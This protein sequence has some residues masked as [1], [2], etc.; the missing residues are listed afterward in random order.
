MWVRAQIA[1]W[2]QQ[3]LSSSGFASAQYA[4]NGVGT[5]WS[6]LILGSHQPDFKLQVLG[7][8][9]LIGGVSVVECKISFPHQENVQ[10][11]F[12]NSDFENETFGNFNFENHD[13]R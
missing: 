13:F 11:N 4:L 2:Y 3:C 7:E 10:K 1:D 5:I 12:G 6:L 8:M 9:Y